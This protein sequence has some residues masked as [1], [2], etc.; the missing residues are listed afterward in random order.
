MH[1]INSFGKCIL[2]TPVSF[3]G[4][5]CKGTHI[6]C[7]HSWTRCLQLSQE[8]KSGDSDSPSF[9]HWEGGEGEAEFGSFTLPCFKAYVAVT[10]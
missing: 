2:F 8:E 9:G 5:I 10:G 6:F 1:R 7:T 4:C 3:E